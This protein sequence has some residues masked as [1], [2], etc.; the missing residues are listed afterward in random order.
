[1]SPS[2]GSAAAAGG[3]VIVV[4]SLNVDRLWRVS[5]LPVA[6]ETLP[7]SGTRV[8]FGGK[9][10]NQAVAAARHGAAVAM[11]GAVGADA[12]GAAYLAH[13]RAEGV[14]TTH[15]VAAEDVATGAAFICVDDRGEN[16][17]V[18]AAGANGTVS[19]QGVERAVSTL[20]PEARVLLAGLEVPVDATVAA[21]RAA[22]AAGVITLF[23][24]SPVSADF[25][26]GAVRISVVIVNERE[27]AQIF[28]GPDAAAAKRRGVDHLVVTRGA[29]PT[30]WLSAEGKRD[31]PSHPVRPV[32]TVGAGDTFAGTMAARLAEGAGLAEAIAFANVAAALS[33][34]GPGAQGPIPRRAVVESLVPRR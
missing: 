31:F 26:W 2:V 25:P 7:A 8:E 18:V 15:L 14:D 20:A 11:V 4:G 28:G 32:D 21:L 30:L 17:I 27:C 13:L 23:N 33:T 9:G 24:P 6:G 16:Q 34:L 10:A 1:M 5:R 29:A 19:A 3:R 22:A 12:D